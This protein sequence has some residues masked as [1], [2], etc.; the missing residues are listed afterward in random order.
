ML[1]TMHLTM[2][3]FI[4]KLWSRVLLFKL[5]SLYSNS[6]TSITIVLMLVARRKQQQYPR[7]K[8]RNVKLLLRRATMR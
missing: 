4:R 5:M 8:E 3:W 7:K 1:C 6:G 2:S